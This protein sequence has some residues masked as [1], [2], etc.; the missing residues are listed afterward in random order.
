VGENN[1]SRFSAEIVGA[2]SPTAI[3]KEVAAPVFASS[4]WYFGHGLFISK[5]LLIR[6]SSNRFGGLGLGSCCCC[7]SGCGMDQ[8]TFGAGYPLAPQERTV[9]K[10]TKGSIRRLNAPIFPDAAHPHSVIYPFAVTNNSTNGPRGRR[11][12]KRRLRK[13][14]SFFPQIPTGANRRSR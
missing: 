12:K 4:A 13:P 14:P 10:Y 3:Q 11:G 6:T 9:S 8:A 1:T 7:C 2:A 5:S